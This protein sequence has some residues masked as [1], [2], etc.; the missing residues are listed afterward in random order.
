M[1]VFRV[2]I[3]ASMYG[4]QIQ[5]VIHFTG[6]SQ[7]TTTLSALADEV[8]ANWIGTVKQRQTSALVYNQV[9]VRELDGTLPPFVKT[10]NIP[11]SFGFDNEVST[12]LAFILRLRTANIGRRGRGRVYIGGVLKGWT[13][14]GLVN[15][16]IINAWNAVATTLL[17]FW[18]P[19]GTSVFTLVLCPNKPPFNTIPVV[20]MQVAPTLGVQRRRNIGIGV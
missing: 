13:T 1:S 6:Q 8:A 20:S 7:G 16:D 19:N 18:G 9:K 11:G 4:Q 2:T 10:V 15:G 12:V 5:N 14:L 17:G 3:I